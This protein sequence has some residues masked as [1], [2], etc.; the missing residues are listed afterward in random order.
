MQ[1]NILIV[2]THANSPAAHYLTIVPPEE[3]FERGVP[4]RAIIGKISDPPAEGA[5]GRPRRSE[6]SPERGGV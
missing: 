5:A 3:S 4:G 6:R 1:F 2:K